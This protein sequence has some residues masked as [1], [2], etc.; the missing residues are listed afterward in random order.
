MSAAALLSGDPAAVV[1]RLVGATAEPDKVL[2]AARGLG[3]R[4]LAPISATVEEF[5]PVPAEFELEDVEL[6]RVADV[7]ACESDAE[8]LTIAASA[9]SPD[10]LMIS[11]DA[12]AVSLLT[13]LL[14]GGSPLASVKPIERALSQVER[15]VCTLFIQR[16]AEALNGAGTRAMH[17]RFPIPQPISG[18]E[19]RKQ[20]FRDGPAATLVYRVSTMGGEGRVR[21]T[22]PQRIVLSPRGADDAKS[23]GGNEWQA[24]FGGEVMRSM[25][26]LQ[27]TVPLGRMTLGEIASLQPGQVIEMSADAPGETRL[28]AKD[29]TLFVCEFG[30]LGQNY[31]VRIK[32]PFDAEA[33]LMSGL[34]AGER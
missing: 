4:S 26:T 11:V 16:L 19:R 21:V 34:L 2:A 9:H 1:E 30:K 8:P 6:G 14:F 20:I 15:G 7:F 31:T 25:V 10:A 29:K 23:P 12:G 27:A 3:E 18:E 33:E 24:R 13:S 22:M 28:S 5:L 17:V 32:E